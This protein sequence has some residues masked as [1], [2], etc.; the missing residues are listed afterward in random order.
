MA[1]TIYK[2]G[3]PYK[4]I[5][6]DGKVAK[7]KDGKDPN[8]KSSSNS[9]SNSSNN[10]SSNSKELYASRVPV[11]GDES[12]K[13][14]SVNGKW[15][16]EIPKKSSSG[17][18][19]SS[20][21]NSTSNNT[22]QTAEIIMKNTQTG[23]TTRTVQDS[24]SG[25][26]I[27]KS[28]TRNTIEQIQAREKQLEQSNAKE[29]LNNRIQS[30]TSSVI[31]KRQQQQ[32]TTAPLQIENS[33]EKVDNVGSGFVKGFLKIPGSILSGA[34]KK[35]FNKPNEINQQF[36]ETGFA[37]E[38]GNYQ[39][40]VFGEQT[41]STE[42]IQ[43]Q[44]NFETKKSEIETKYK[45]D[46]DVKTFETAAIIAS[47]AVGGEVLAG[48]KGA[49]AIA[50]ATRVTGN[51]INTAIDVG[52]VA[53][54]TQG[55]ANA[56]Q[57]P[58]AENIG[59]AT[60]AGIAGVSGF[61]GL[62]ARVGN[63][64]AKVGAKE[65]YAEAVFNKKALETGE[66]PK[67]KGS[68]DTYNKFAETNKKQ[69]VQGYKKVIIQENK[70]NSNDFI[71]KSQDLTAKE[72]NVKGY[73]RNDYVEAVHATPS[74]G[75]FGK[76]VE[77]KAGPM[78]ALNKEDAILFTAPKGE[79]SSHFLGVSGESGYSLNP[80]AAWK[81]PKPAAINVKASGGVKK[82]PTDII[83][84]AKNRDF[85]KVNEFYANSADKT[86][87][88]PTA[89]SSLGHTSELEGGIAQGSKLVNKFAKDKN[90]IKRIRGYD[91]YVVI[92]GKTVP[93]KEYKL[94][95]D[96]IV[97][98]ANVK[99]SREKVL[100]I[101]EYNKN[102][103][104]ARQNSNK[105]FIGPRG[106][107]NSFS[108]DISTPKSN[109]FYDAFSKLKPSYP[110][111]I[112]SGGS[113]PKKSGSSGGVSNEGKS[114]G[115]SSPK[116]SG[117][118]S[119][120]DSGSSGGSSGGDSSIGGSSG[121]SSIGGSSGG[122]SSGEKLP[123]SPKSPRYFSSSDEFKL[124][125]KTGYDVF[126]RENGKRIKANKK[127]IP[128]NMAL[129]KGKNVVDNTIAASFEMQKRGTTNT[130]D[131]PSQII[132]DK[133]RA[134]KTKNALRVVEKSKNRIDTTGEKQGLSAAK[135]LRRFRL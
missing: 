59:E 21:S 60:F 27:S 58:T 130:P 43:V 92:E 39:Q 104:R 76:E 71:I 24:G 10:N 5:S 115:G 46:K 121:G 4:H 57:N 85:T 40:I 30:N 6:D 114:S 66:L 78:G 54:A 7:I 13:E 86:A 111:K 34:K 45:E 110:S 1:K 120:P 35:F 69:E 112:S 44:E 51:V 131:I 52:G 47:F 62:K 123:E 83:N 88:Y 9:S 81:N 37:S 50:S 101:M 82:I 56:I 31:K 99:A 105:N 36:Q 68:Q 11:G 84:T 33:N 26:I 61:G 55:V 12:Q 8:S 119:S 107:T 89:R 97:E 16:K 94:V 64:I 126:I 20:K 113:S 133:F 135:F 25:K 103:S 80:L 28:T 122:G 91:K 49:G 108:S 132:G 127:P 98:N 29:E 41:P 72:I 42:I 48:V 118:G 63:Q 75:S 67:T 129:K 70:V 2:N 79:G 77:I 65:V 100:D 93:I 87:V 134:R 53:F 124:K 125:H 109:S 19:S 102:S 117:P 22:G 18:S 90:P 73:V 23:E 17:S 15:V 128:Y 95:K 3:K 14:Y 32:T 74:R 38:Y 116:D 96:S 106:T